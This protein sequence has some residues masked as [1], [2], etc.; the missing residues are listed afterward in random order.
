MTSVTIE[1]EARLI[2]CFLVKAE[3][4]TYVNKP[5]TSTRGMCG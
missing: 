2:V 4:K 3:G 1:R 5:V